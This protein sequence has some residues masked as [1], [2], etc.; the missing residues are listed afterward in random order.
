MDSIPQI[1]PI[2]DCRGVQND[3]SFR[4]KLTYAKSGWTVYLDYN[5]ESGLINKMWP[6]T[7]LTKFTAQSGHAYH[8]NFVGYHW[9]R[10][11]FRKRK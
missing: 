3:Y 1:D 5:K 9:K 10:R 7:A 11:F 2:Y 6:H 4:T 8:R